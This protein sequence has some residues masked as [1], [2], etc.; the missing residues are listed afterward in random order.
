MQFESATSNTRMP[1]AINNPIGLT[2]L[3]D[4]AT[5]FYTK[6]DA[7]VVKDF[8]NMIHGKSQA[9]L[10]WDSDKDVYVVAVKR[11]ARYDQPYF[12]KLEYQPN[13]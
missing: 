12:V 8:Y 3:S 9:A 4:L 11:D 13:R 10:E 2:I 6:S 5:R 7:I 1:R